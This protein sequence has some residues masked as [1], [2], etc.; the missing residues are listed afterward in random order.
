MTD[1]IERRADMRQIIPL[2]ARID[3]RT[4][5]I[6]NSIIAIN[7]HL[8][9]LNDKV[10]GQQKDIIIQDAVGKAHGKDI[11]YNRKLIIAMWTFCS[12]LLVANIVLNVVFRW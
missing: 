1:N 4:L 3:E 6:Q 5:G 2:I 7:D 10:A 8:K 12:A 11:S 9:T